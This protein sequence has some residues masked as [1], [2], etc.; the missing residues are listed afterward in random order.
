G[1][2]ARLER[3]GNRHGRVYGWV[4][5]YARAVEREV[6]I[7]NVRV[8]MA[9]LQA[10][11]DAVCTAEIKDQISYN[12]SNE[13]NM[14][15]AGERL[16][17]A[18]TVLFWTT[19]AICVGFLAVCYFAWDKARELREWTVLLTGLFPA[20]GGAM[21]AVRA[22]ADFQTVADRSA[23]TAANLRV[24]EEAL[25]SEPLEFARLSDRVEKV[26]DVMMAD[27]TEWH[28]MFSTRPL[29]LPA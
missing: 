18:G 27:N 8:D 7:P 19:L 4:S 15:R 10:V 29:S 14:E 12:E 23:E 20:L 9:Y 24:L 13:R 11:R 5:W 2:A 16:H 3:P 21:A 26:V 28:V 1:S 22:Q 17:I 6:P 25:E